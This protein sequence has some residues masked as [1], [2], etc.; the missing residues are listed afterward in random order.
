MFKPWLQPDCLFRFSSYFHPAE[1]SIKILNNRVD[2]VNLWY[3]L[4]TNNI[5]LFTNYQIIENKKR[6]FKRIAVDNGRDEEQPK[7]KH[8]FIDRVLKLA[9]EENQFSATQVRDESNTILLAVSSN[10]LWSLEDIDYI[11]CK[12]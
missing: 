9:R 5:A 3:R 2:E 11:L 10:C 8:I 1:K 7:E 4:K 6:D 12:F